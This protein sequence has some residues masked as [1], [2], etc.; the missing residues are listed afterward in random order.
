MEVKRAILA[1]AV[2]TFW[3]SA[4]EFLRN[5]IFFHSFWTDHFKSLGIEFPSNNINGAVWGLWSL[6]LSVFIYS[7][8]RKFDILQ[9]TFLAWFACFVMI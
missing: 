4:S 1:V 8:S 7:I 2:A 3:I 9:T 5:Q 6:M